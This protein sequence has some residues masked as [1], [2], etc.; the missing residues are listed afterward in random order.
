MKNNKL[1]FVLIALFVSSCNSTQD[2]SDSESKPS[3]ELNSSESLEQPSSEEPSISEDPYT[4]TKLLNVK[5]IVINEGEVIEITNIIDLDDYRVEVA[6]ETVA[7]LED[8]YIGGVKEGTT[9]MTIYEDDKKQTVNVTVIPQ[10]QYVD[11]YTFANEDLAGKKV[12]A[13]GDSVT[14]IAT[15][16]TQNANNTYSAR[17]ASHYDMEFV[18]NYAIGGTT[19]TY[20]YYGSNIYKEYSTNKNVLDGCQVVYKAYKAGE[21]ADIDYAFIAYGHNDQYFQPPISVLNDKEYCV[22]NKYTS[23]KSYKGSYRYMINVLRLANPDIKIIL[24]NCTYS[25]YDKAHG[26]PY[27]KVYSYQR[28]RQATKEIA[29]E[30]DCKHI[31]P[32]DYLEDYY[33]YGNGNIYYKD[34]VHLSV[35]GHKVLADYIISQ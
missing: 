32:W 10:K 35:Q 33:D 17:F 7:V 22:D 13:F 19:A 24:L 9:T 3:E 20:T 8:I 12:V 6:D 29:I 25:E 34:S 2:L 26:N 27:G 1:L 30:M 18:K 23:C 14:A 11:P 21:L 16:G 4:E 5:D 31:D 28:Y 15:I